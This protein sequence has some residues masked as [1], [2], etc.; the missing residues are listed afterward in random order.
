MSAAIV[1]ARRTGVVAGGKSLV[2]SSKDVVSFGYDRISHF[3]DAGAFRII[4]SEASA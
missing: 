2:N 3:D 4:V 1:E